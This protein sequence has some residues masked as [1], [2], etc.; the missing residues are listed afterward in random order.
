[1]APGSIGDRGVHN[2]TGGRGR[3]YFANVGF[4]TGLILPSLDRVFVGLH[5]L[6][7]VQI[8]YYACV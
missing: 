1:M 3:G 6:V 2:M 4:T 5:S 7:R 8:N